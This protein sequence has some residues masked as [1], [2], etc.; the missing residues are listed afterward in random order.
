MSSILQHQLPSDKPQNQHEIVIDDRSLFCFFKKAFQPEIL[1]SDILDSESKFLIKITDTQ[2]SGTVQYEDFLSFILPRTKKKFSKNILKKVRKHL[3]PSSQKS[4]DAICSI[5]RLFEKEVEIL[6]LIQAQI[7]KYQRKYKNELQ[8]S[9]LFSAMDLKC[10]G[11]MR[12]LIEINGGYQVQDIDILA[13]LRRLDTDNDGEISFSDFFQNI[14]PYFLFTQPELTKTQKRAKIQNSSNSAVV[15][16]KQ[17]SKSVNKRN[18]GI[19][20]LRVQQQQTTEQTYEDFMHQ[21]NENFIE[22]NRKCLKLS[23]LIM[24]VFLGKLLR[25]NKSIARFY[26]TQ[27]Q[28]DKREYEQSP[29]FQSKQLKFRNKNVTSAQHFL[30]GVILLTIP[31][32][33]LNQ[34]QNMSPINPRNR[35]KSLVNLPPLLMKFFHD[36]VD[37]DRIIEIDKQELVLQQDYNIYLIYRLFTGGSGNLSLQILKDLLGS[38]FDLTFNYEEIRQAISRQ[39]P[40]LGKD[41][42][43]RYSEF[44]ILLLPKNSEFAQ[45][46]NKKTKQDFMSSHTSSTK[47]LD[48]E[49]DL[50]RQGISE[51]THLKLRKLFEDMII[52]ESELEKLRVR[53]TMEVGERDLKEIFRGLDR[54]QKG[55]ALIDD[56]L[57]FF[58]LNYNG[59]LPFSADDIHYLFK[60]HDRYRC[61]KVLEVDFIKEIVPYIHF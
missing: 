48:Q 36:C 50:M 34:I 30:T 17:I 11:R 55:H 32:L 15:G 27:R 58:K 7:K 59:E 18:T 10:T 57:E 53:L 39:L 26:I 24:S 1:E 60:R 56:Y 21:Q 49:E 14:L 29:L 13:I 40:E 37:F 9:D 3:N 19:Q 35:G 41:Q 52:L 42:N 4:Y 31:G 47:Y 8:I 2:N 25:I 22:Q 5:G 12:Q 20:K 54:G 45:Y 23:H 51:V 33:R 28:G 6:R 46:I 43:I 61:G 44:I 38:H 16:I